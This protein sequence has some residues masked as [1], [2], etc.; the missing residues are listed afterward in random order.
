MTAWADSIVA[1]GLPE[2]NSNSVAPFGL[3]SAYFAPYITGR[4]QAVYSA[5][6]FADPVTLLD[7]AFRLDQTDNPAAG[8]SH[9]GDVLVTLSV[10]SMPVDGLD[11]V[12][13]NNL[14]GA[15]TTVHSGALSFSWS[16]ASGP[17]RPFDLHIPLL[18]PFRYDPAQ[19]NLLL[20][21]TVISGNIGRSSTPALDFDHDN[22]VI[23]GVFVAS[24]ATT[25]W[26]T[27]SGQAFSGGLV[28]EFTTATPEPSTT[29]LVALGLGIA[30]CRRRR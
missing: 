23:S 27:A 8:S 4:Y 28:T 14:T 11:P 1:P 22:G 6:L 24:A 19:G 12:F 29:L 13:A 15:V 26:Q 17:A 25:G 9:L 21:I 5:G 7:I 18:A 20:D 10:T 30:L 16:A 3:G 2:G